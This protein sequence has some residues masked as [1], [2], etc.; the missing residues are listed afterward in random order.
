M[1]SIRAAEYYSALKRKEGLTPAPARMSLGDVALSDRSG[2]Q[3][4]TCC[5]IALTRGSPRG[6]APV[7]SYPQVLGRHKFGGGHS[8]PRVIGF[9]GVGL[10]GGLR[11]FCAPAHRGHLS[12][13]LSL[14]FFH[15]RNRSR[16]WGAGLFCETRVSACQGYAWL[17][18]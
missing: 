11:R 3:K 18:A 4:D 15:G 13:Q 2:S 17:C 1:W 5:V 14:L 8:P 12:H 10:C 16:F 6:H 7:R 9:A